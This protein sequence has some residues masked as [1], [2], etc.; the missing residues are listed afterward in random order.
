MKTH[1]IDG[2]TLHLGHP[3]D[4]PLEWVGRRDL[5]RQLLAAWLVVEDGDM[6]LNPRL[7]GRPGVGK[8]TLAY[9]AACELKRPVWL[10]QATMDTR[11]EDLLVT[12][13]LGPEGSIRYSASP[14]VS[15]MISGGVCILDEGNRMSE[16]SW[17]S[18]APLLDGRR[19]IESVVAGIKVSAHS[20]FRFCVTMNDDAS[21]FDVPEYIHSR[22]QP[23]ILIDFPEPDEERRILQSNIPFAPEEILE[24]VL[25]F[26]QSS[27][28]ADER[29]TVRDG[30]NLV[31]YALKRGH[32]DPKRDSY[33]LLA[34][35]VRLILGP[36]ALVYLTLPGGDPASGPTNPAAGPTNPTA[37]PADPDPTDPD[38]GRS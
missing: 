5:V 29:F 35:A 32:Q 27:H 7:V 11:P 21:T 33:R 8:T 34:E 36:E 1:I 25:R 26:L 2:V 16:K 38:A 19:Y 37:D 15:A 18:L 24:Y 9:A 30:I 31:R 28:D 4:L 14:L 10:Y 17:A 12:P 3:D 23:Q 6:P 22:L 13:V 20:D